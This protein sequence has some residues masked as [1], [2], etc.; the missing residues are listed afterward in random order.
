MFMLDN[1]LN[2]LNIKNLS[3]E[4]YRDSHRVISDKSRT[5]KVLR[6]KPVQ[7]ENVWK[8]PQT[9]DLGNYIHLENYLV[10][11]ISVI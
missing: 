6:V 8:P 1:R 3:H 10:I 7:H 5:I 11:Q 4:L 2:V 9:S